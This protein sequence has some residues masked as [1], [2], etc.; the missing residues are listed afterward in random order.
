M[1]KKLLLSALAFVLAAN[2]SACGMT[3][4]TDLTTDKT[5]GT[6]RSDMDR[7]MTD[8]MDDANQNRSTRRNEADR[9]Y[10]ATP[11]FNDGYV[12]D[13]H[14]DDGI[15]DDRAGRSSLF[16]AELMR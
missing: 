6:N 1:K 11:D 7:T 13:G 9:N 8:R 12:K 3:S 5:N 2:L 10:D 16:N 15:V 4:R 14:A